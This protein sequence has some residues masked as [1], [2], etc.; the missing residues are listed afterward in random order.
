MSYTTGRMR[1]D[2]DE[3]QRSGSGEAQGAPVQAGASGTP[4]WH[5]YESLAKRVNMAHH[6]GSG[7]NATPEAASRWR[8]LVEER[9]DPL[10]PAEKRRLAEEEQRRK[11]EYQRDPTRKTTTTTT[12]D[13]GVPGAYVPPDNSAPPE[14]VPVTPTTTA[15]AVPWLWLG[16]AAA[17]AAL[18][19]YAVRK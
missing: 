13:P 19:V 4:A 2:P 7:S 17:A 8:E 16:V 15:P 10:S 11:A 3:N 14:T 18:L 6:R 12:T 5:F 1:L 9:R